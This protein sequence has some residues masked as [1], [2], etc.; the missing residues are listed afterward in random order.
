[1]KPTGF[2]LLILFACASVNFSAFAQDEIDSDNDGLDTLSEYHHR[3]NPLLADTD[4]D[5][6]SDAREVTYIKSINPISPDQWDFLRRKDFYKGCLTDSHCVV[7]RPGVQSCIIDRDGN[8]IRGW[9][10]IDES[11][12]GDFLSVAC[13]GSVICL[14]WFSSTDNALYG[15]YLDTTARPLGEKFRIADTTGT[16]LL[17]SALSTNGSTFYAA[18]S[19]SEN[20]RYFPGIPAIEGRLLD[21]AS[22]EPATVYHIIH[23]REMY[24]KN[25][26]LRRTW[27]DWMYAPYELNIASNGD[28]YCV[29]LIALILHNTVSS[30]TVQPLAIPVDSNGKPASY[31]VRLSEP[32]Q[33]NAQSVPSISAHGSDYYIVHR[34][35]GNVVITKL[36]K[37]GSTVATTTINRENVL[38]SEMMI[39]SVTSEQLLLPH[40]WEFDNETLSDCYVIDSHLSFYDFSVYYTPFAKL[41]GGGMQISD[42][43]SFENNCLFFGTTNLDGDNEAEFSTMLVSIGTNSSPIIADTDNDGLTDGDEIDVYNTK[44]YLSDTDNDGIDDYRELFVYTTN[45]RSRDSDNDG[46]HD[47]DEL[48]RYGTDPLL[49]DTDNDGLSDG[50]ELMPR[51]ID[52]FESGDF[53]VLN[54]SGTGLTSGSWFIDDQNAH[55]GT[56]CVFGEDSNTDENE[57]T[58]A[59]EVPVDS[60]LSFYV[61]TGGLLSILVNGETQK[62]ILFYRYPHL[63][64]CSHPTRHNPY[65]QWHPVSVLIPPGNNTV[66]FRVQAADEVPHWSIY[67]DDIAVSP[68]GTNYPTNPLLADTD[69]DGLNDGDEVNTLRT[70]PR[71]PDTDGD[72]TPDCHEL[73]CKTNPLDP[74]SFFDITGIWRL[75]D[76]TGRPVTV[77]EW[78]SVPG[79]RYAVCAKTFQSDHFIVLQDNF[80]A[81]STNSYFF[82][83]QSHN[84]TLIDNSMYK[85]ILKNDR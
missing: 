43:V 24:D 11:V 39:I 70:N 58:L 2:L 52:S 50:A 63:T 77:I 9:D 68:A 67:L 30:D 46:I 8:L 64:T 47:N 12:T 45:P 19:T 34:Y 18:W 74:S 75:S 84:G 33:G 38:C 57:L 49:T 17:G 27:S 14:T 65:I 37:T 36:D 85:I 59:I 44:P 78:Q 10:D 79:K 6:L 15:I 23:P 13:N 5:G 71:N 32:F 40:C 28:S 60:E 83:T 7:V 29:T 56:H 51:Y 26:G 20:D 21:P 54:W 81:I 82:H 76:T 55:T 72:R 3:T 35:S 4:N 41:W 42:L 61:D 22:S 62:S 25:Y 1:M 73:I 31:T 16:T 69:N 53:S 66:T 80:T 48:T